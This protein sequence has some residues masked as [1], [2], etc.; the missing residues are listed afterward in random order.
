MVN[1]LLQYATKN[2]GTSYIEVSPSITINQYPKPK[3]IWKKN[4]VT[5]VEDGHISIS[6][7]HALY[8]ANL[9]TGDA[10]TY[11]CEVENPV[12][13]ATGKTNAVQIVK[14]VQLRVSGLFS[15]LHFIERL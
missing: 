1:A 10:G 9:R 5:I 15:Y 2:I 3:Y 4:D 11:T 12:M 8:I 14:R 13:K 7:K 6:K